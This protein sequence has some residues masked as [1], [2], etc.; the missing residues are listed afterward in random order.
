L[1]YLFVRLFLFV[2]MLLTHFFVGWWLGGTPDRHWNGPPPG[3]SEPPAVMWPAPRWEDLTYNVDYAHLKTAEDIAAGAISFWVYL[4][5]GLLGAYAISFYFSANTIIYYL[6][7]R[8]VDAT[9]LDDVYVEETEDEFGEP[10]AMTKDAAGGVGGTG[11]AGAPA[12]TPTAVSASTAAES[13][14][15]GT[16]GDTGGARAYTVE[17]GSGTAP[18]PFTGDA[19]NTNQAPGGGTSNP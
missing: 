11:G 3:S 16:T 4:T 19:G 15:A 7:R 2:M 10:V 17:G 13:G 6:M 5:I 18:G 9:E 12:A 8:E 14:S 1:T